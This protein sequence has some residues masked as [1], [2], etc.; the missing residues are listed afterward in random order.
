MKSKENIDLEV[1]LLGINKKKIESFDI[2][3]LPENYGESELVDSSETL[4]LYKALKEAGFLCANSYDLELDSKIIERR[5]NDIWLGQIFIINDLVLPALMAALEH[6]VTSKFSF[7][8]KRVSLT[9]EAK[10]HFEVKFNKKGKLSKFKFDGSPE[11][12][13]KIIKAFK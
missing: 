2:L 1:E 5:G 9:D 4:D 6:Y 8:R 11:D 10:V 13:I 7:E 3:C 12:A